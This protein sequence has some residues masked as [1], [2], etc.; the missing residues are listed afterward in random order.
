[1]RSNLLA[2]LAFVDTFVDAV[3]IRPFY[4]DL[5]RVAALPLSRPRPVPAPVR[6]LE[7]TEP[8]ELPRAA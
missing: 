4:A 2:R 1:M 7:K 6:P 5:R 3:V 8:V